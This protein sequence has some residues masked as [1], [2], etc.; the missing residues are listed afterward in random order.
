MK[1][2]FDG[3]SDVQ[4]CVHTNM[5]QCTVR[6]M[7]I[8]KMKNAMCMGS[9]GVYLLLFMFF[10]RNY[11]ALHIIIFISLKFNISLVF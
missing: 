9:T 8:S 7:D 2:A 11:F 1:M 4:I 6:W 10:Q 5:V 3:Q